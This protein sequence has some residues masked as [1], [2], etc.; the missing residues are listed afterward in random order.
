MI[1][2]I[3]LDC[4]AGGGGASTGIERAAGRHVDIA[5]N[6][7]AKALAVHMANHPR[8]VHLHENIRDLHP[9][10]VAPGRHIG[11]GWFSP[12][13]TYYSKA[14]GGKPF[15]DPRK[16][17][18]IRGLANSVI[19]WMR[20]RRPRVVMLENVEE[21][22]QWGPLLDSGLPCP[23]RRGQ[24]FRRWH[25][26]IQNLGYQVDMRQ[27][28]AA[29]YGAGTTRKR[30]F[31]IAR[32]DGEEIVFPEAT[33]GPGLQPFVTAAD[34]IDWSLPCPSIFT[35]KKPLADATLRRIAR[36]VMRYVV[37]NPRPFV[38]TLRGTDSSH[39]GASARSISEPLRTVSAAGTHHALVAPCVINTRNGERIGQDP[40][41]RDILQPYPTITAQGSQGALV[42]AF[43][44]RHYGGHENDGHP[45]D[46]PVSTITTKDHHHL[47]HAFLL[48]YYGTD[49]DPRLS[50]PLATMTTKHRFG[51]V[52]VH[53]EP[54]QIVDIGMRMLEPR[55]LARAT[56]FDDDYILDPIYE[57]KPLSKTDQV[58]MIGN[59]V[60]PAVAEALVRANFQQ[61]Q[62]RQA[63]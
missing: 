51:L 59:A 9:R 30:L 37:N 10:S 14:R 11:L 2:G 29:R 42:A 43:L 56:S 32:C 31:V 21:F 5:I 50:E 24:S 27:L 63:A 52:M 23:V 62:S 16:A 13:C 57:G 3:I 28:V 40:R 58:W 8:T 45:L 6:H 18:R 55:E 35:R 26:R 25:R 17:M 1:D 4:F 41:V 38:V 44:A 49:Q 34:C 33:H 7:N 48:K 61:Q 12:D 22:S 19:W 60:P 39:I 20:E 54:Y 46:I 36:G 15:R 47:V 53:G